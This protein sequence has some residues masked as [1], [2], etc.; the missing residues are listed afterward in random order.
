MMD[1]VLQALHTVSYLLLLVVVI[2]LWGRAF[3]SRELRNYWGLLALA[4]TMTLF[5]N[6]AWAMH[7]LVAETALDT[8]SFVDLFYVQRYWL[9][10]SALWLY[11]V[12]LI[13]RGKFWIGIAA[14][15]VT[16]IVWTGYFQPAMILSSGNWTNFLGLAIYPIL[17]AAIITLA[18]L[19]VR[20]ARDSL[21]NRNALLLFYALGCYGI[22]N[23]LNLTRYVFPLMPGTG[24]PNIFW[25]LED[26]FLLIMALGASLEERKNDK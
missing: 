10:G 16:A 21:W 7:D 13:P 14:F 26:L 6:I 4:W 8:L 11:P 1:T 19:R 12:P 20:A 2:V 18:W 25:I 9:I 17:D 5:G 15:V 24:M 23:T 3:R 22:A